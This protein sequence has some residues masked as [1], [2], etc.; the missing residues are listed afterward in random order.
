LLAQGGWSLEY[1]TQAAACVTSRQASQ[2]A[3]EATSQYMEGNHSP[4]LDGLMTA[5]RFIGR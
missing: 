3:I 2:L 5:A 4:S 1:R